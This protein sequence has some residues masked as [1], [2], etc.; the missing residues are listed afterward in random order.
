MAKTGAERM[1]AQRARRKERDIQRVE[2][3]L[4]RSLV[5]KVKAYVERLLRG[6]RK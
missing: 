1:A 5:E 6:E 3:Y 4:P 2:F